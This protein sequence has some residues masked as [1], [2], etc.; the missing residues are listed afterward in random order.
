MSY[1]LRIFCRSD[2]VPT[3]RELAKFIKEGVYFDAAPRFEPPPDAAESAEPEWSSFTVHYEAGKRPVVLHRNRND[4]VLQEEVRGLLFILEVSRKT[5][6]RQKVMEALQATILMISIEVEREDVTEEC[7]E[8]LDSV[9]SHIA[10][11]CEGI[12]FA[13]GEGFYDKNLK[14]LKRL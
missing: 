12:L 2:D 11:K 7:W 14:H 1:F 8:M 3:R 10:R 5:K 13:S 4:A 9:E 6:A